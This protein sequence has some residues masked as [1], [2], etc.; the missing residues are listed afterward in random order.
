MTHAS[1][2]HHYLTAMA[3]C[4]SSQPATRSLGASDQM[5]GR[6]SRRRLTF[7][8]LSQMRRCWAQL[9]F[10]MCRNLLARTHK[11]RKSLIGALR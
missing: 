7:S 9:I 3:Y 6:T 10:V 1:R 2:S 5:I 4:G 11:A 8:W